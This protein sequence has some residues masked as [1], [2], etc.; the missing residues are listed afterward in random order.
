[1]AIYKYTDEKGKTVYSDQSQA[2]DFEVSRD[3]NYKFAKSAIGTV[4]TH[5]PKVQ[6]YMDYIVYLRKH[7]SLKFHKIGA[8]I[9][10]TDIQLYIKLQKLG[11]FRPLPAA[12][13]LE[14]SME[15]AVKLIGGGAQS[16][17]VSAGERLLTEYMKKDGFIKEGVLK[18][19]SSTLPQ[20]VPYYSNTKLGE[21]RK[22][23]N[24][25]AFEAAKSAPGLLSKL[26]WIK[27]IAKT[28]SRLGGVFLDFEIAALDPKNA[29]NAGVVAL[30]FKINSMVKKNI[31]DID[32]EAEYQKLLSQGKYAEL[33]RALD[34]RIS[35]YKKGQKK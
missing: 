20:K 21:W 13:G 17:T 29:S 15:A 10:K 2:G 33:N 34:E 24:A 1:M 14:I 19:G 6:V 7:N 3:E 18:A 4:K 9:A 28:I 26:P 31:I 11:V 30:A 23:E 5:V 22:A 8:E 27:A 12:K 32:E 35:A 25:A 16:A